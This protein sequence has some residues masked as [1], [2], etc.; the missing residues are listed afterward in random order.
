MLQGVWIVGK[1]VLFLFLGIVCIA[2]IVCLAILFLAV[3]YQL[4]FENEDTFFLKGTLHW[5]YGILRISVFYSTSTSWFGIRLFGIPIP[6]VRQKH[7]KKISVDN[8]ERQEEQTSA[9]METKKK[10]F[11]QKRRKKEE[12]KREK[13]TLNLTKKIRTEQIKLLF[14]W[15]EYGKEFFRICAPKQIKICARIGLGDAYLT[16]KLFGLFALFPFFYRKEVQVIPEFEKTCFDA[17]GLLRGK[18]RGISFL[19]LLLRWKRDQR[20]HNNKS[21]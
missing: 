6:L 13:W 18:M 19:K 21:S 2:M 1:W 14:V 5:G 15:V 17:K 10:D 12:K 8:I 11:F 4:R 3:H 9:K 20:F 7:K 16:G